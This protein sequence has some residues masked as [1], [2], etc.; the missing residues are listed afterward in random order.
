MKLKDMAIAGPQ[1]RCCWRLAASD[2]R[3]SLLYKEPL[4]S[5]SALPEHSQFKKYIQISRK[6]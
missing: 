1:K 3:K 6:I 4:N 5:S 2:V